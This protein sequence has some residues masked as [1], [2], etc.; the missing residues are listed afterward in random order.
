MKKGDDLNSYDKIRNYIYR[1][2]PVIYLY[3]S[4]F[5]NPDTDQIQQRLGEVEWSILNQSFNEST[6]KW[7]S[8]TP[9]I[10]PIYDNSGISNFYLPCI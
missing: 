6:Q 7:E 1:T 3:T 10:I 4:T 8:Q 2:S 5:T 9:I